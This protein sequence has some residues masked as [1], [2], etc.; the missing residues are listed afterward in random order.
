MQVLAGLPPTPPT[1]AMRAGLSLTDTFAYVYTSGARCPCPREHCGGV[2]VGVCLCGG[3]RVGVLYA[4]AFV[5]VVFCAV[6][7]VLV[8]FCAVVFVLV[9]VCGGIRVGVVLCPMLRLILARE[10]SF[11]SAL[12]MCLS[13]TWRCRHAQAPLGCRRPLW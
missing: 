12:G 11:G 9:F 10:C 4:V 2:R 5:L 6:A 1:A 3:V 13:M 8:W 7:F